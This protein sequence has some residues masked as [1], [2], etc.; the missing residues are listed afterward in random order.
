LQFLPYVPT[1]ER[2]VVHGGTMVDEYGYPAAHNE[3]MMFAWMDRKGFNYGTQELRI[4]T[5][6]KIAARG[7]RY[8]IV[9]HGELESGNLK[10]LA[11]TRYHRVAECGDSYYLYDLRP[12]G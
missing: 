12:A 3:S 5:L 7:G 11:N 2:I 1:N 10:E 4:E 9:R 6:E 8:W